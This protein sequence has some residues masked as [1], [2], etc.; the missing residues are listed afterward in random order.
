MRYGELAMNSKQILIIIVTFLIIVSC[1]NQDLETVADTP[2]SE[3]ATK[4]VIPNQNESPTFLLL[5]PN[6][7]EPQILVKKLLNDNAGCQLPCWWGIMPGQTTW[8]E[9]YQILEKVSNYVTPLAAGDSFYN[10]FAQVYLP[11]PHDF[12]NYMEHV[13]RVDNGIVEYIV[14]YNFNLAPNYYLPKFLE[15]Y[16]KPS[17][18]WVQSFSQEEIGQWNFNFF[19]FYIDKGIF[20]NY[21]LAIPIENID[22]KGNLQVCLEEAD[23]PFIHLWSPE[24]NAMSFQDAKQKFIDTTYLPEPQPLLE[25]T[26]MDVKTFYETFKNPDTDVCLETPKDL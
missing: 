17:E 14:V 4:A 6:I 20:M 12:E 18:I 3:T 11:Y 26:G 25:A 22:V 9:A 7:F 23:S 2:I 1:S 8:D 19:L 15:I 24:K 5:T 10:A 16:G 21:G 13:Y